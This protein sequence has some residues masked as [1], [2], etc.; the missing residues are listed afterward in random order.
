MTQA[1]IY[2]VQDSA[3]RG[4]WRPGFS[5]QW[6]DLEKDDSLC[7]PIMLDLPDWRERYAKARMKGLKHAGCAVRGMAGIHRWFTPNELARLRGFGFRLVDASALR[8]IAESRSQV[9]VASMMPLSFLPE[10]S[11]EIAA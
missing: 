9:I 6:V 8:V 3:G 7:P 11:W 1:K 4:P 5:A 10:V 2:R